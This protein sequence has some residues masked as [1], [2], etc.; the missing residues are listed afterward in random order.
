MNTFLWYE[1]TVFS[2][3]QNQN[4]LDSAAATWKTLLDT[5][6]NH[7]TT[8][9]QGSLTVAEV[10][11]EL[12]RAAQRDCSSSLINDCSRMLTASCNDW[13]SILASEPVTDGHTDTQLSFPQQA[14]QPVVPPPQYAPVPCKWWYAGLLI[15]KIWLIFG[16]G[17]KRPG[18]LD[19][20]PWNWCGMSPVAQTT[21][22]SN[23]GVSATSLY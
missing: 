17:V 15:L 3:G 14:V 2:H 9:H 18:D 7:G 21:L 12:S 10:T 11:E 13:L 1:F 22:P 19:L 4:R 8:V 6:W 23:F 16:H 5:L 20:W